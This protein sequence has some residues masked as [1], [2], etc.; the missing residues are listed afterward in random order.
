MDPSRFLNALGDFFLDG[1]AGGSVKASPAQDTQR[2]L[3]MIA[4]ECSIPT[5]GEGRATWFTEELWGE[6]QLEQRWRASKLEEDRR[7]VKDGMTAQSFIFL[8]CHCVSKI[9]A[10][11]VFWVVRSLIQAANLEKLGES[12]VAHGE[13]LACLLC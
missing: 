5:V 7:C 12:S 13:P 8:H 3:D 2:A 4:P 11:Q 9:S 6:T 10:G 1:M